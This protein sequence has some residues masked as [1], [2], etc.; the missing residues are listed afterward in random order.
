MPLYNCIPTAW[1]FESRSRE[2]PSGVYPGLTWQN[3]Y[4]LLGWIPGERND[5]VKN[6]F[7]KETM[8]ET[9]R[10]NLLWSERG[11]SE[12]RDLEQITTS[13]W[14]QDWNREDEMDVG[15]EAKVLEK[16]LQMFRSC[17]QGIKWMESKLMIQWL[18]KLQYSLGEE[19]GKWC[20]RLGDWYFWWLICSKEEN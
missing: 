2:S 10:K 16:S 7:R 12:V 9:E 19:S 6:R 4:G 18:S 1:Q 8:R 13:E 11:T 14:K 3:W 15:I 5:R 17:K 20:L